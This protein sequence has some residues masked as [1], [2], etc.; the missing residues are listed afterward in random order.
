MLVPPQDARHR[1]FDGLGID[2]ASSSMYLR[3]TLL[4]DR[5]TLTLS[6]ACPRLVVRRLC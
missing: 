6:L 2:G 4:P 5:E 3:V 1:Y